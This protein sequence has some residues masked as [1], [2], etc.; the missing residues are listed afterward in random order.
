MSKKTWFVFII[1]GAIMNVAIQGMSGNIN[2][3]GDF[4]LAAGIGSLAGAAGGF[5]GQ[6]VA[7]SL[8]IRF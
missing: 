6:A 3:A 8:S 5:A 1:V 4:F 2:S 7:G